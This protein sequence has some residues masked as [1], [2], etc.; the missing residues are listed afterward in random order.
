MA[1]ATKRWN[2][3]VLIWSNTHCNL[4]YHQRMFRDLVVRFWP[5]RQ[6][7]TLG[8][9]SATI[10][11]Q[12]LLIG[13]AHHLLHWHLGSLTAANWVSFDFNVAYSSRWGYSLINTLKL[14]KGW[15]RMTE[16]AV[17]DGGKAHRTGVPVEM[18]WSRPTGRSA[19]L[20]VWSACRFA[21]FAAFWDTSKR[22]KNVQ[23][24]G[25]VLDQRQKRNLRPQPRTHACGATIGIVA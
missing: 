2:R 1:R 18:R 12:T 9:G 4:C 6:C 17:G 22:P 13:L 21:I 11:L 15:T 19:P 5:P 23:F 7:P 8:T 14:K 16:M 20:R 3:D 25:G 10:T 24:F